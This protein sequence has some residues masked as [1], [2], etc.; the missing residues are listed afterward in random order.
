[1]PVARPYYLAKNGLTHTQHTYTKLT[2]T[3]NNNYNTQ[4][5]GV[6]KV[7]DSGKASPRENNARGKQSAVSLDR[8][9]RPPELT[10]SRTT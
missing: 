4:H 9:S 7:F 6:C 10:L 2:H 5:L 8:L 3:T 1:M